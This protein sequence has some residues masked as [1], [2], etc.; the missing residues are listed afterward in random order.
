MKLPS[1]AAIHLACFA[2]LALFI[3]PGAPVWLW[4]VEAAVLAA[5]LLMQ[6]GRL[7]PWSDLAAWAGT[8][9]E[10]ALLPTPDLSPL[11]VAGLCA[12]SIGLLAALHRPPAGVPRTHP[13]RSLLVWT[14]AAAVAFLLAWWPALAARGQAIAAQDPQSAA[15]AALRILAAALLVSL[16]TAV[17]VWRAQRRWRQTL[18]TPA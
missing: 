16:A 9:A 8:L 3:L 15:G 18:G 10:M 12:A 13:I 11:S 5:L 6:Y 17:G 4:A 1:R 2:A 7:R 14:C